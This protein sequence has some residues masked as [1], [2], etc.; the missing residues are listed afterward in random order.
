MF[1]TQGSLKQG[2]LIAHVSTHG[3]FKE[4]WAISLC[5]LLKVLLSKVG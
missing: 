3:S 5:P 2:W 4:G 1:F